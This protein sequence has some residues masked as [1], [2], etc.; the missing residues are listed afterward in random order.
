MTE[1][2]SIEEMEPEQGSEQGEAQD[3][4]K[5]DKSSIK[6]AYLPLDDAITIAKGVH[7]CG[8]SCQ[9][10]QL[11]AQ[12]KQ[13]HD[14]GSFRLKLGTTKLFGLI[15]YAQKG[16]ASLTPLGSRICDP[17]Q[18]QQAKVEAFLGVPLYQRVYE[19]FK[20]A[21]L[22]P[23]AGLEAAMVSMGVAPKQKTTA[24]QVFTRS[25]AQAG[26]FWSGEGR[27]VMPVIKSSG[28][29]GGG[30]VNDSTRTNGNGE[31]Q[32]EKTGDSGGSGGGGGTDPAIQGL[33]KRLPAPDS[34][35]PLEK[36]VKWLLAIAHAFE[37]VYPREDD[38]RS[39]RIEI[40]KAD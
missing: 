14:T 15:T 28:T 4:E 35:W 9:I 30:S 31:A 25:A 20:G 27:L 10:D 24:R 36:Q 38:V 29:P 17:Q 21:T 19:Q 18:E 23:S 11:A 1:E 2:A 3:A 26:F 13:K 22:P 34:D 40:V 12:L 33:I 39:L 37:V 16:N 32:K 6:F 7:E 8:G 5:R